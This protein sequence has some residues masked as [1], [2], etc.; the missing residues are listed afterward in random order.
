MIV[1]DLIDLVAVI[2]G[3]LMGQRRG[4]YEATCR[5]VLRQ[6][7]GKVGLDLVEVAPGVGEAGKVGDLVGGKR[8]AG[9]GGFRV[10]SGPVALG[11]IP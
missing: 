8:R 5:P 4:D 3:R 7:G 9:V 1:A 10:W 11:F 2:G 6:P